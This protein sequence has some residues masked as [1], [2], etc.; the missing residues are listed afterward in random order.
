MATVR[1]VVVVG[2]VIGLA[3]NLAYM[4]LGAMIVTG[5]A[6]WFASTPW[7][8]A[9]CQS[10]EPFPYD[11]VRF[12]YTL[13]GCRG[14]GGE[15]LEVTGTLSNGHAETVR[16]SDGPNLHPSTIV[17]FAP[18]QSFGLRWAY[19]TPSV[20]LLVAWYVG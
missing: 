16:I 8:L 4:G 7:G 19:G 12:T 1:A 6:P 2:L 20:D 3:A 18:D 10:S 13:A 11:G 9:A 5:G 15:T 17:Q 14:P